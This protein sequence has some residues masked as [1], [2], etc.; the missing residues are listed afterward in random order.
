MFAGH[1]E[2]GVV[3]YCEFYCGV[4]EMT[5]RRGAVDWV[6][7]ISLSATILFLASCSNHSGGES[8]FPAIGFRVDSDLLSSPVLVDG[9]F[10]IQTPA[11][12]FAVQGDSFETIAQAL[13]SDTTS[14]LRVKVL[15]VH[16]SHLGS[17]CVISKI[18][19]DSFHFG[20]LDQ[21]FE[22]ML[23]RTTQTEN[24]SRDAFRLNGIDTVQYLIITGDIITFKLFSSIDGSF[25]Q[26]DY[27][28]PASIYQ[29]EMRK[30][31]SSIGTIMLAKEEGGDEREARP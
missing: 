8:D 7:R 10:S 17:S 14:F 2:Y 5:L 11:D 25:Y 31:E 26:M 9:S 23:R 3:P 24:V 20:L 27:F 18:I 28:V 22:E 21:S 30:L 6:K 15:T 19:D 12:W 1:G 16:Q 4:P 13:S 29:D